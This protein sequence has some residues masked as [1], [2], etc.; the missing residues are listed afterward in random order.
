[1][2]SLVKPEPKTERFEGR[3]TKTQKKLF[4]KAASIEGFSTMSEYMIHSTLKKAQQVIQESA[5]IS[6]SERDRIA[7]FKAMVN[8]PKPNDYLSKAMKGYLQ[9][10]GK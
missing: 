7:F 6:L 5:F 4:T 10:K 2:A 9:E 8:P 1:M 3:I